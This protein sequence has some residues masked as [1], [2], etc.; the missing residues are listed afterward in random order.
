LNSKLADRGVRRLR[1]TDPPQRAVVE[2]IRH[3]VDVLASS[4]TRVV[5]YAGGWMFDLA[6]AGSDVAV[7]IV[8]SADTRPLLILG[9][10][11]FELDRSLPPREWLPR[12]D[13][14][15]VD[16]A[17]YGSDAWVRH[18]THEA[19]DN[20]AEVRLWGEQ[21]PAL[22]QATV[23]TSHVLSL[24]ARAF[25]AEAVA[26]VAGPLD[27][28]DGTEMFHRLLRTVRRLVS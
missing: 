8:E 2:P 12:P 25:K 24:A 13:I 1:I 15:A 16:A 22:D 27:T 17:L 9:A 28:M 4:A 21:C 19:V 23:S 18:R 5:Q 10:R 11:P 7:H 3:R 14:L 6:T 20:L 26:A